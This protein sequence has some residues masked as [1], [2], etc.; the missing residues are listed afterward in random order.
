[1]EAITRLNGK[2]S[3][4][5]YVIS[6]SDRPHR[7]VVSGIWELPF[8]RGKKFLATAPGAVDK[9]LGGWQI[10]G[11]Y[12][13]Q[14]GQPF[15]FGNALYIGDIHDI[16][17]PVGERTPE[18]WF[19]TAGFERASARQLSYNYRTMP[20]RLNNVRSAGMNTWDLSAIKNTQVWERMTIQFRGEFLNA[21]NRAQF[22]LP[23][24]SPTSTAFGQVTSQTGYPRRIQLGLKILF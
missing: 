9:F 1:M 12:T 24:T 18:R 6:D 17:L 22:A 16:T 8:G 13:A 14:S 4:L 23:N 10:Q 2:E 11:I 21:F 7:F 3:P 15:G 5:E 20:T 19:N